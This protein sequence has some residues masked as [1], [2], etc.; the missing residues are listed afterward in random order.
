[1]TLITQ[2]QSTLMRVLEKEEETRHDLIFFDSEW[3][4]DLTLRLLL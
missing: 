3:H 4:E 2:D 1:M